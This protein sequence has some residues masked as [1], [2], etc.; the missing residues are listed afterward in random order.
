[1][2]L[3]NGK[4][5]SVPRAR[6]ISV[7]E[8]TLEEGPGLNS[9]EALPAAAG[10]FLSPVVGGEALQSTGWSSTGISVVLKSSF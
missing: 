2:N 9:Q 8:I 4:E 10:I 7:G 1:M 3:S 5:V 6:S